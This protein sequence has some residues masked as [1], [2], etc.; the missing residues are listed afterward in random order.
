M[1]DTPKLPPSPSEFP[2]IISFL[3]L[4]FC[5]SEHT[6]A[7]RTPTRLNTAAQPGTKHGIR[8]VRVAATGPAICRWANKLW[9]RRSLGLQAQIIIPFPH[10]WPY[11]RVV[12]R[13]F[14]IT[15]GVFWLYPFTIIWHEPGSFLS[16]ILYPCSS[17][18]CV[19]SNL[20]MT[21]Y[22]SAHLSMPCRGC[23]I[24]DPSTK[25]DHRRSW[26]RLTGSLIMGL[27]MC[28]VRE[29]SI[30]VSAPIF[31]CWCL[32]RWWRLFLQM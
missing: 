22:R 13:F 12:L 1:S 20:W 23:P 6:K 17:L 7:D 10:S 31:W 18:I 15:L 3:I 30:S 4:R 14:D 11:G 9:S 24:F 16:I 29:V 26:S 28:G 32:F 19:C 21:L 8:V 2:V 25:M 27:A 5:V